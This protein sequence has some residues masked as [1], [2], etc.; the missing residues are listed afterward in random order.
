MADFPTESSPP[1]INRKLSIAEWRDY[2]AG[3][4]FTRMA[5]SRL[6]LHHTYKP[7]ESSWTGL[8][9]MRSMQRFYA[10]KGWTAAP[11][12]YSGPDGIWLA[13]PMS[14]VGIHAGTGNGSFEKGWYSIGLE[15]VGYFDTVRPKG[16]VWQNALAVMGE[17]SRR[18]KIPPRDLISF[19]RD[20]TNQKSCPG[21]A[22]TK[23]W[24]WAEV[25]AYL[26]NVAPPPAPPPGPI[27]T[28]TPS[29]EKLL[30][31]LLNESYSRKSGAQGYNPDWA[32]HQY[33]VEHSLGMPMSPSKVITAEGKQYNYQSFAKDTLY[34]EVPNWGDVHTLS[35]LLGGSIPPGG[36]GRILLDA[37]FQ[38]GGS[39][40]NPTWAFHQFAVIQ[41]IG[42][43]VGKNTQIVVDGKTYAYQPFAVDTLYSLAPNWGDVRLLS[44]L[45]N[46]TSPADVRLRDTLL[47]E[48]YKQAGTDYHPEWSF[49]QLARGYNIGAP[50]SHSYK[51][52]L[53]QT[54]YALQV[55]ALDTLYNI[56]PNWSQ[57][58]RL[59]DLATA[60]GMPVLGGAMEEEID[61]VFQPDGTWE[62]PATVHFNI[63]RYSPAASAWSERGGHKISM[64]ILHGLPG[65]EATAL[66]R[67]SDIGASFCTHYYVSQEGI[68]YQL[69]D[70]DKAAWHAGMATLDGTWYNL[71]RDSIGIALERP[72]NW[73]A[74]PASNTNDQT[75]ALRWLLRDLDSRYP[76]GAK[77]VVLWSSFAG[78]ESGTLDG[79]SLSVLREAVQ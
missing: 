75:L 53:E 67:M 76:L 70:E 31:A 58:K 42:P 77:G 73:P 5:P 45:A 54:E 41:R 36:L 29:D 11:H 46:V 66:A 50:L 65:D 44:Q 19:H 7:D 2:V 39:P 6:V 43:P 63:V 3:Y 57:V 69:V 60:K 20:Y 61:A 49:H 48:T 55:Y 24:V 56:V 1:F 68:I 35:D 62:P 38:S 18:L 71:N 13:T 78:G 21:W 32:F 28:P 25:E 4:Q 15:M 59:R 74:V 34:C 79:L 33:A 40:F 47:A 10:G 23:E 51:I 52:K 64:A 17:L 27:G 14:Q 72:V 22:V 12:I 16:P 37:T 26:N 9:S 30:E 8:N